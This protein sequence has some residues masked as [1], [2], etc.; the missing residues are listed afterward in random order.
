MK[1][2]NWARAELIVAFNLYCKLPFGQLHARSPRV[3]GLAKVLGRTPGSVAMKLVNFAALDPTHQQR[4]VSG[5]ANTSKADRQVWDEFN[6][7]WAELAAES[8]KALLALTG[9]DVGLSAAEDALDVPVQ[10]ETERQQLMK[11]RLG[12]SFFRETVLASYGSR[13]CVCVLPVAPLLVA[14]HIVPWAARPDLRVN[15]RNGL[16]LCALHDRA[17]DRGLIT[18]NGALKVSVSRRLEAHLPDDVIDK[19]F[20]AYRGRPIRL[21]EKF[22]PQEEFLAYHREAVFVRA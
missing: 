19:M 10:A 13:C 17:F 9:K 2:R 3:V 12:Q 6:G 4:G 14:S 22:R 7:N 8:E 20:V 15:P 21:P 5:L 11:A 18:V 16:C 1:H